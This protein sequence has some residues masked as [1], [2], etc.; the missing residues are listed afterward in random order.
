MSNARGDK[1]AAV[2]ISLTCQ[3]FVAVGRASSA[4]FSIHPPDRST[5]LPTTPIL[6]VPQ[7]YKL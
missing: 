5:L 3:I 1:R 4:T 7:Q 2:A 6:L